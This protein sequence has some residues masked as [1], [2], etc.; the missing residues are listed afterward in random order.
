MKRAIFLILGMILLGTMIYAGDALV[1]P[2]RVGRFYLAPTMIFGG[3][4]FDEDGNRQDSNDLRFFNLGM[5]LEYGV[6]NWIT[7]AAQWTPGL[8]VWSTI[9]TK[10]GNSDVRVFDKGDLFLGAKM[11][12]IGQTAPFTSDFFRLSFAPGL[13]VPLGGPDFEEQA[14]NAERGDPVTPM[15]LDKHVLGLGLRSYLDYIVNEN[16]YINFYNEFLFY[17]MKR[18]MKKA[19]FSEYMT[20]TGINDSFSAFNTSVSGEVSYGYDLTFELEPVFTM[21]LADTIVFNAGLPLNF[22]TT[23][24]KNYH[25][26]ASGPADNIALET[27]KDAVPNEKQSQLFTLGASSSLFF[28]GWSV[29]MEFKLSYTCPVWGINRPANHVVNLQIRTY[30]RI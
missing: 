28:R 29:P 8:N 3:K 17:P 20:I 11:Q 9:D 14:K 30:F 15:T 4:A 10:I 12:I 6:N 7:G 26:S 24:G 25:F 1:M 27:I 2:A 13:K 5:A 23:R 18:D 19:G 16:F 22:S 21:P